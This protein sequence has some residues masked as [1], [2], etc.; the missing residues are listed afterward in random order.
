MAKTWKFGVL[1]MTF[2][3][4]LWGFVTYMLFLVLG[5]G[6]FTEDKFPIT[7]L[8]PGCLGFLGLGSV[9]PQLCP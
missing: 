8:H 5:I 6:P 7:E 3:F 4:V 2:P 1:N 9:L